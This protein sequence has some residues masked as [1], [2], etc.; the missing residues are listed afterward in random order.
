MTQWPL[1]EGVR[2]GA[3][4]SGTCPRI[5]RE[6]GGE[7]G[8]LCGKETGLMGGNERERECFVS[9]CVKEGGSKLPFTVG[10]SL[11]LL[12]V[13][14]FLDTEPSRRILIRAWGVHLHSLRPNFHHQL[15]P[16]WDEHGDERPCPA[17]L[18]TWG[19]RNPGP[20]S[21]WGDERLPPEASDGR[22]RGGWGSCVQ[23]P[24][25]QERRQSL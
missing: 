20:R 12:T 9:V 22:R 17:V 21:S 3:L 19:C 25:T 11:S 8:S 1:S 5:D 15:H 16:V 14:S 6:T 13:V 4:I 2:V 18:H 7:A 23:V 24:E 10:V